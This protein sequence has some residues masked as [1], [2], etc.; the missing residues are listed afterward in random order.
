MLARERDVDE[1]EQWKPKCI[2]RAL[3][4]HRIHA[5]IST[6]GTCPRGQGPHAPSKYRL[7][8]MTIAE[9]IDRMLGSVR[10]P[11]LSPTEKCFLY[12]IPAA[13]LDD[14]LANV[15]DPIDP[16][17]RN[18]ISENIWIGGAGNITPIH[19]DPSDNL[20]AQLAGRKNVL[21]WDSWQYD[22]LD[23]NPLGSAYQ[24]HS[25]INVLAPDHGFSNFNNASALRH[26][27]VAGQILHIPSG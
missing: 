4:D 24:R 8:V 22:L 27:L 14:L 10:N 7:V 18:D 23:L 5:F 2:E 16:A 17:G 1:P 19:C 9:C 6:D 3:G 25:L 20:L 26:E 11:V 13:S 12:Q 21:L 15:T